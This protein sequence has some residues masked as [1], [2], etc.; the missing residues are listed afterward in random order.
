MFWWITSVHRF[1][2]PTLGWSEQEQLMEENKGLIGMNV[3]LTCDGERKLIELK[4]NYWKK[5]T[6][7]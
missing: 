3:I 1:P 6:N 2:R 4:F 5:L 7:Y